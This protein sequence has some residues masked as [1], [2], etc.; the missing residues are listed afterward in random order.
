LSTGGGLYLNNGF[1]ADGGGP[2]GTI[3]ISGATIGGPVSLTNAKIRNPAGPALV[4]DYLRTRS[5]MMLNGGFHAQGRHEHGTVRLGGAEI[6]GRLRCEN[7]RVDATIA[8][9][10]AVNLSKTHV[11]GDV[12]LPAPFTG[13]LLLI[14]GFTYDGT[15]RRASLTEWLDMLAT[16]TPNYATQPYLQ[17]ASA[18]LATGHER[19]V[20]RVHL[21]RQRDLLRRGD[22][23]FCGRLWH[24]ITGLT[25]GYGYRP[26][27][28]LAWWTGAFALSVLLVLGVAGP[29]GVISGVAATGDPRPCPL[30]EQIGLALNTATPLIRPSNLQ[31]CVIDTTTPVGQI[32]VAGNWV[33]RA[34]AWAFVTLF[35]AGFTRLIRKSP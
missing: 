27:I 11:A 14:T 22:L 25:V 18:H 26:A 20:R 19:D 31:T 16:Q 1:Q 8:T 33:L 21:A 17:L 2:L 23:D 4:A 28:A 34:L 3:R 32:V 35:I 15:T 30:V 10:L 9:D 6:G 24:R 29:A 12:S 13:G 7:G 5:N